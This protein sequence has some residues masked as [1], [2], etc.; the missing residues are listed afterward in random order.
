MKVQFKGDSSEDVQKGLIF[1][2]R[3]ANAKKGLMK[4]AVKDAV[5][6]KRRNCFW[7][8]QF[9]DDSY[10]TIGGQSAIEWSTRITDGGDTRGESEGRQEPEKAMKQEIQ[11]EIPLR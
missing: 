4:T 6:I 5:V 7:S 10:S 3:K 11:H 9:T 2:K 1:G 8:Q